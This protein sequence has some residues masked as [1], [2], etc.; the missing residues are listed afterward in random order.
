MDH[1][2]NQ[3]GGRRKGRPILVVDDEESFLSIVAF[4]LTKE[5]Y[6]VVTAPN[7]AAALD[8]VERQ[9]P[10]LVLLDMTLPDMHGLAFAQAYRQRSGSH[11]PIVVMTAEVD[12]AR[13]A[14][15]VGAVAFLAKPFDLV[16]LLYVVQGLALGA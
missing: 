3:P 15:E 5:G 7:G 11:A 14:A 8:A 6:S 9:P 12:A 4:T 16:E 1:R 2:P 13:H 10:A